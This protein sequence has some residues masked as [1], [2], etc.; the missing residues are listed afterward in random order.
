MF[1]ELYQK[2]KVPTLLKDY[3]DY[4]TDRLNKLNS[5]KEKKIFMNTHALKKEF[6]LIDERYE[7]LRIG[8]FKEIVLFGLIERW[9]E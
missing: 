1:D 4:F 5:L 3:K 8:H 9:Y 7:S 6:E 2:I